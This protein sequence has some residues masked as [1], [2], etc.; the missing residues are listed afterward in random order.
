MSVN[1]ILSTAYQGV[2]TASKSA[3]KAASNIASQTVSDNNETTSSSKG[4]SQDELVQSLVDLKR[5][6]IQFTANAKVVS[7]ASDMIGSILD[8]KA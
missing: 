2:Q 1:S 6:E 3:T 4:V 8:I 5:S 7:T